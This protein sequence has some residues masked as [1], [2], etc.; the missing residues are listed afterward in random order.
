MVSVNMP[1]VGISLRGR[2]IVVLFSYIS[3]SVMFSLCVL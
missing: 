2:K 3:F 1:E